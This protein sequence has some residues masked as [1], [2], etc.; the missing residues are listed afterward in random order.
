MVFGMARSA[1]P[2]VFLAAALLSTWVAAD[3]P[4]PQ[5]IV[6]TAQLSALSPA[7]RAD[8]EK[9]VA[10]LEAQ[11]YEPRIAATYRSP[12]RQEFIY[13]VGILFELFG[14]APSTRARANQSCHNAHLD[15]GTPASLAADLVP[16]PAARTGPERARFF[17]AMG[18]S[19]HKHHLRWGGD[20]AHKSRGW[21]RYGLGWDPAHLQARQC[22]W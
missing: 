2:T 12:G 16:G 10:E 3:G 18:R 14:A 17:R 9:L 21:A 11:G 15:D 20:W 4:G 19:A 7:F 5:P 8:L 1:R 13:Q 22:R 6:E